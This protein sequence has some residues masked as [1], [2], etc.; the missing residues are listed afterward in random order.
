MR[1]DRLED[2]RQVSLPT[3]KIFE[4]GSCDCFTLPALLQCYS[5]CAGSWRLSC[6]SPNRWPWV[7]LWQLGWVSVTIIGA[8]S[9]RLCSIQWCRP[10]AW[11]NTELVFIS[12]CHRR[13]AISEQL[14][15]KL[16][17]Q[18]LHEFPVTGNYNVTPSC[19]LTFEESVSLSTTALTRSEMSAVLQVM[20][21]EWL[22]TW[23][24][25][26]NP[27]VEGCRNAHKAAKIHWAKLWP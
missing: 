1:G 17:S 8:S 6:G 20:E 13:S 27:R 12:K 3:A 4:P 25:K 19:A 15:S 14:R 11:Q 26:W 22:G 10:Q 21:I 23:Q 9:G 16:T 18:G 24:V 5:W 7:K 2:R